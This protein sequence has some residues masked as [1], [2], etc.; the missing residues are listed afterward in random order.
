MSVPQL[1]LPV[2]GVVWIV[3]VQRD[4]PVL[5]IGILVGDA[6]VDLSII[7]D[8][9]LCIPPAGSTPIDPGGC[10]ILRRPGFIADSE[11]FQV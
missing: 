7:P 9:D 6:G 8:P 3:T 4:S 2:K 5:G 11:R 1:R 10:V